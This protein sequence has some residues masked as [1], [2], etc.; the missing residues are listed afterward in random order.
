VGR[1]VGVRGS[2]IKHLKSDEGED[3]LIPPFLYALLFLIFK[4]FFSSHHLF[5]CYNT[6]AKGK[7]EIRILNVGIRRRNDMIIRKAFVV[8]MVLGLLSGC[9]RPDNPDTHARQF[10]QLLKDG[11][12]LAVQEYLSKDMKQMATFLGGVTD[13]SLNPYYRTGRIVDFSLTPTEKTDIAV[14]YRVVVTC[15]DGKKYQDILD[16]KME[17]GKWCVSRF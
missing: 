15:T 2:A 8:L 7:Q 9:G 4:A 14:R 5:T 1:G 12:H 17:D 13:E 11:K 3:I 6:H 16:L 10:M